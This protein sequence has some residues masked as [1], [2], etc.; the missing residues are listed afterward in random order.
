[1]GQP[2]SENEFVD[3][4]SITYGIS[5]DR[6]ES[7]NDLLTWEINGVEYSVRLQNSMLAQA[8]ATYKN[9]S[10]PSAECVVVCWGEPDQYRTDYG[11]PAPVL[12]PAL[13]VELIFED[14][15]LWVQG[16]YYFDQAVQTPT[17]VANQFPMEQFRLVIPDRAERILYQ[18]YNGNSEIAIQAL[19]MYKKWP[20]DWQ[21]IN[22]ETDQMTGE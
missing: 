16:R 21:D 17:F 12:Q 15:G 22:I 20:G 19:E 1:M 7:H 9:G 13:D 6:I 18:V 3:W 4:A 5:N 14:L 2:F 8:N 10:A 11:L